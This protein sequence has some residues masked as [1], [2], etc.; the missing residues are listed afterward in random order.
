MATQSNIFPMFFTL[1]RVDNGYIL[2]YKE[3][4]ST[5]K[6]NTSHKEVVTED[7]IS[8]RI[9]QLLKLDTLKKEMPIVFHIEAVT[10]STYKE[11]DGGIGYDNSIETK[12]A[13]YNF[14]KRNIPLDDLLVLHITDD[15][16]AN[17]Y[18]A[19]AETFAKSNDMKC[20]RVGKVPVLQF[21][22]SKE[23]KKA[24]T[25]GGRHI[26]WLDVSEESIK[27]WYENHQIK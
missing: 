22:T 20:T 2:A 7:K 25:Q 5:I 4:G 16:T 9:G 24:V 19:E 18:G 17:I 21:S 1:E 26:H 13:F 27:K 15:D 14:T 8:T 6:Q 10:E 11:S 23:G 3:T 12:L